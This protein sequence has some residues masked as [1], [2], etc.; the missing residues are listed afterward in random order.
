MVSFYDSEATYRETWKEAMQNREANRID[1]LVLMGQAKQGNWK[2]K[3]GV[4]PRS[5][6]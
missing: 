6:F 4:L 3:S 2:R 1:Q 5:S